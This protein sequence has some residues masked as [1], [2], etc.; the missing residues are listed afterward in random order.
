VLLAA[1]LTLIMRSMQRASGLE[2]H[3]WLVDNE[4]AILDKASASKVGCGS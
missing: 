2:G 1:A 3:D 4:I